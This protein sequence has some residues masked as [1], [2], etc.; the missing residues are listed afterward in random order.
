VPL[1][2]FAI[3]GALYFIKD[4]PLLL[5][6]Q[7]E[8]Q[9]TRYTAAAL[10]GRRVS[11][12]GLGS[13]GGGCVRAFAALGA[14]V[15]GVGRPGGSY[16]VPDGVEVTDTDHLDDVLARTDVLVLAAPLTEQTHNL[17]DARRIGLLP[18]GAVVVNVSR[19][20]LLDQA[21]LIAA[22]ESGQL[23]GAALDVTDPEPPPP[24][25]PVWARPDVLLS[26]HSAATVPSE[27]AAIVEIF[28][29]NLQRWRDGRP[30]RNI[31]R[32][33]DGY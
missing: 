29:D 15:T 13:V 27:N 8:R 11:V 16:D 31:Y 12:V 25:D 2:E 28:V 9:W 19:G 10:S 6:R 21:A 18:A 33:E 30:L 24:E 26:P 23:L 4:V 1:A 17:I 22:L 3:T 14:R 32:R 7:E 5:R 20:Q